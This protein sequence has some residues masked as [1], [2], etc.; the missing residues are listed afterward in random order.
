[1]ESIRDFRKLLV[2]S[3]AFLVLGVILLA[4]SFFFLDRPIA[5]F[6][7]ENNFAAYSALKW[8]TDIPPILQAWVPIVLVGLMIRRAWGPF[9]RWEW[10]VI[11]ASVSMVLADQFR[12]TLA[13]GF[14]RYWPETWIDNN[15][16]FIQDGAYG[17]HPFHSGS[18]YG[19]CPSGHAA[20][21][22]AITSTLW[23]AYPR[24]RLASALV[25][26]AEAVGLIGMNYHF[27]GDVIAGGFVGAIVG[28]WTFVLF[29]KPYLTMSSMHDGFAIQAETLNT[30]SPI[31]PP[32]ATT[33]Q[34]A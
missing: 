2:R 18:A 30:F 21:T 28:T 11:A 9:H 1:M 32:T 31:E 17:F 29:D 34:R 5:R 13:F 26:V 7:Y 33:K 16:S 25:S 6:V 22:L 15:P 27:L 14:G 19:S 23:I 4:L 8:L 24:L 20:R 3:L 12:E 10:I